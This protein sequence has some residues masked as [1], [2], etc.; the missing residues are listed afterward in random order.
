[1]T[2]NPKGSDN[3]RRFPF[4][5]PGYTLVEALTVMLIIGIFAGTTA[6]AYRGLSSEDQASEQEAKKLA[7]WLTNLATISNRTGRPFLLTCPGSVTRN[8][9]E[10]TWQNPLKKDTYTSAYKCK[11][12]RYGGTNAESLY[13]PQ[14]NALTPTITIKVSCGA[15]EH[16]VIASQHCRVRTSKSPP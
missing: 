15:A 9:I 14:W 11:F 1:M 6:V 5:R 7:R 4:Y 3:R 8:Y 10:A 16:Y 13:S 2:F 12:S